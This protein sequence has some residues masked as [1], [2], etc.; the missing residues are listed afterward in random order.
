[1]W[2]LIATQPDSL[3]KLSASAQD[4]LMRFLADAP[5]AN[6]S[7]NDPD[8][9]RR[10]LL[11]AIREI[12]LQRK[13]PVILI[14]DDLQWA[15]QSTFDWLKTSLLEPPKAGLTILATKR[16]T[17]ASRASTAALLETIMVKN[18][19][20]TIT[21]KPLDQ[22]VLQTWPRISNARLT[23]GNSSR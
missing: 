16:N 11:E 17:E 14:L 15:D 1:M 7:G 9:E 23:P 20:R 18:L 22:T 8:M 3:E 21:L 12:F 10:A 6:D 4:A 2:D 5:Q 19:G 13:Q